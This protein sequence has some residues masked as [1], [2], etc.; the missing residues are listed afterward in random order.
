MDVSVAHEV[1]SCDARNASLILQ[2]AADV[3][4]QAGCPY[5]RQTNSAESLKSITH[6][7]AR[8]IISSITWNIMRFSE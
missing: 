1:W 2:I 8:K 4:L 7:Q 5:W 3:F 6:L